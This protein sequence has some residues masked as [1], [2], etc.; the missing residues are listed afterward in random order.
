MVAITHFMDEVTEADRVAVLSEGELVMQG[1]PREIFK[2]KDKLHG[3]R[4]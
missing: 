4:S 1:A 3:L 2:E